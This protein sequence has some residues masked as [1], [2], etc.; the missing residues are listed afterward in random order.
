MASCVAFMKGET[1]NS[2]VLTG[3]IQKLNLQMTG[4]FL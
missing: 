1:A 2:H 3:M 4:R